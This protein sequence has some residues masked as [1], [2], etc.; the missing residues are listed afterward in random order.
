LDDAI[1]AGI[2]SESDI[3]SEITCALGIAHSERI[4]TL[5]LDM[6]NHS[7]SRGE[8]AL[9]PHV[10]FVFSTFRD[11]MYKAVYKNMTVKGE[12]SKILGILKGIFDYFTNIP[13]ELPE[14]YQKIAAA[15]G[16]SRAIGDYISGM[17]DQFA[18]HTYEK[19]FIPEAWQVR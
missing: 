8:I 10:S 18:I 6:I 7:S 2:L 4:N 17:T 1:R 15:D 16:L 5:I 19:L 13:D 3:P 12:E 11:F 9:S 14:F